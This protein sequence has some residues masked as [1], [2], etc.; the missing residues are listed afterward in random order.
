MVLL[1]EKIP[2]TEPPQTDTPSV[3]FALP[4]FNKSA[5]AVVARNPRGFPEVPKYSISIQHWALVGIEPA[6]PYTVTVTAPTT[7]AVGDWFEV[8]GLGAGGW[9]IAQNASQLIHFGSTVTT[10]GTG[11]YLSSNN[12]YD[13]VSMTC[14]VA[15]TT[16]LVDASQGNITVN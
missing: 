11:G 12:Q 6:V 8:E 1:M 15:N 13:S 16:W 2:V 9:K 4:E 7:C 3:V 14:A 5:G 10:T